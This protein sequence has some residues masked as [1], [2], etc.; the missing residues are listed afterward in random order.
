ML[1]FVARFGVVRLV[2]RRAVPALLVWDIAMLANRTR[3]IPLVDR[4]LRR[5]AGAARRGVTSMGASAV[6][7]GRRPSRE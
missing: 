3:R 4:T 1:R 6:R 2:G 7:R 5:G